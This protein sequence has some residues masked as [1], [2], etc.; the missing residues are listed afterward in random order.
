MVQLQLA[1]ARKTRYRDMG[2]SHLGLNMFNS[3]F[4]WI[5]CNLC[6]DPVSVFPEIY[7]S[8]PGDRIDYSV[9]LDQKAGYYT[10]VAKTDESPVME[11]NYSMSSPLSVSHNNSA[12]SIGTNHILIAL[13]MA[14]WID[15]LY[16]HTEVPSFDEL[17]DACFAKTRTRRW[18]GIY[19]VIWG[20]ASTSRILWDAHSPR[21]VVD[22]EGLEAGCGL[23]SLSRWMQRYKCKSTSY[24]FTLVSKAMCPIEFNR[25]LRA[26]EFDPSSPETMFKPSVSIYPNIMYGALKCMV[27]QFFSPEQ[28]RRE[29][30][31]AMRAHLPP[32][33]TNAYIY[34]NS[35]HVKHFCDIE[36]ILLDYLDED[37]FKCGW[38]AR[39]LDT[40][41]VIPVPDSRRE[42]YTILARRYNY[43]ATFFG[44]RD[45]VKW[46]HAL[47]RAF[48]DSIFARLPIVILQII[49]DYDIS[50]NRQNNK[51]LL[52]NMQANILQ[53]GAEW[54]TG[55]RVRKHVYKKQARRFDLLAVRTSS[56]ASDEEIDHGYMSDDSIDLDADEYNL[57]EDV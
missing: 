19:N 32:R 50:G 2:S 27:L 49:M 9:H 51:L 12:M 34:A 4:K 55:D 10:R 29:K 17:H 18:S 8:D 46:A 38:W 48:N 43:C 23:I 40:G 30:L 25:A 26:K 35:D 56:I 54:G 1:T 13:K 33:L 31:A 3:N 57:E 16:V 5:T 14:L 36:G 6:T 28:A 24:V 21:F 7:Y 41:A 47:L 42:F 45:Q 22:F 15:P 39:F 52:N 11:R 37:S 44:V 20:M 53:W